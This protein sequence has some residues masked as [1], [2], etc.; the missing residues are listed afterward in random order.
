MKRFK[1]TLAASACAMALTTAAQAGTFDIPAGDLNTALSLYIRQSGAMIS[2]SDSAVKGIR[3]KGVKGDLPP[4]QALT[5]ILSGT[6]FIARDLGGSLVII[7][8]NSSAID[9]QPLQL[10]QANP[11]TGRIEEV[12]VTARRREEAVENIPIS[13]TALNAEDLKTFGV[14]NFADLEGVV[15][16]L[17]LGG[18]GNGVKRDS[19][20][21]IRGVGQ[22]ETKVTLDSAVAT[23]IDGVY[24]GRAAGAMLDVVDVDNIQVLRGPQGTLFGRNAT[25]GALAVTLKKPNNNWEGN[26][27]ANIGN[28]GR[29][30]IS[31]T[32]NVPFIEDMLMGRLTIS[33]ANSNGYFTN[34][35]DNTKWGGDNRITGIAQLRYLPTDR[36]T[37]DVLGERTRIRETPRPQR[38][39]YVRPASTFR[40]THLDFINGGFN[41]TSQFV[42]GFP[43]Y[44]GLCKRSE[45]LKPSQFASDQSVSPGAVMG[46]GRYWVDTTTGAVTANWDMGDLAFLSDLNLKS[47][48]AY[49]KTKQIADED[50]DAVSAPYIIRI[51]D[52]FDETTQWSQELTLS[53]KTFHDRLFFNTGFYYFKEK[54]PKNDLIISAGI[55]PSIFNTSTNDYTTY[56]AEPALE[57]LETD[58]YSWAWYGQADFDVTPEVQVTAGVRYTKEVRWSRYSKMYANMS[59]T[60]NGMISVG[61]VSG[62]KLVRSTQPGATPVSSWTFIGRKFVNLNPAGTFPSPIDFLYV[63]GYFTGNEMSFS[64][65]AWTPMASLKYKASEY[66]LQK[67][68]LD[69]AMVYATYSQGFHSGGVT[70]GAIDYGPPIN[71]GGAFNN[72]VN[73]GIPC[74]AN[75][76][77]YRTTCPRFNNLPDEGY[78]TSDPI[79]YYPEKLTNYEVGFKL[80]GL[81]RR[82][83]ANLSAFYMQYDDMQTTAVGTRFG[84]PVPYIENVGKSVIKGIEAEVTAMPTPQWRIVMNGSYTDADIKEW[85]SLVTPLNADATPNT[86]AA[87]Y[88]MDRSD[89]RMPRVPR[90]Q[91][92]G[93]TEYNFNLGSSGTITP[94]VSVRFTSSIYHGFDRGSWL[95]TYGGYY[96]NH[97]GDIPPLY[98]ASH[99]FCDRPDPSSSCFWRGGNPTPP[100]AQADPLITPAPDAKWK[101]TSRPTAFFDARVNWNS[102]DGRLEAALWGKNLFNKDDY[103]VGGIPLADVL[104]AVGQVY[105]NPRTFGLTFTYHFGE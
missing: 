53:G 66:L 104:G 63:P 96:Y 94:S 61:D 36:I 47:I 67:L 25:G 95:Y 28:Y 7:R 100:A 64:N 90:W 29:R 92:F 77:I 54:T 40:T 37:I 30:D 51:Q 102:E 8:G 65:Q 13:I 9:I 87:T 35:V 71:A 49:R 70:S 33:S 76:G 34:V 17:N 97:N 79:P 59:S 41:N 19:S 85:L 57:R 101:T 103:L 12:L 31:G 50:L 39:S 10:A 84:I 4:D 32:I 83:Q 88:F 21:F 5:R 27:S 3:T 55:S 78:G 86:T 38:C 72:P 48:S 44:E 89:E 2:V 22:R 11:N 81:D 43:R 62:L 52:G 75:F 20:P 26:V 15:P 46:P 6:G 68:R 98:P 56:F 69:Q 74:P 42:D 16:G 91:F 24:I 80:T 23:Y 60:V 58:N 18:G 1:T 99:S 14:R 73:T 93:S 45:A 105:A 82:I